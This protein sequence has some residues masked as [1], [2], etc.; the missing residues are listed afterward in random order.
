MKPLKPLSVYVH[1]PFCEKRCGY[2]DFV[3]C[4]QTQD[5]DQYL[6]RLCAEIRAFNFHDYEIKTN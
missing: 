3:S 5:I 6:Q 2:C 1:I 4:T